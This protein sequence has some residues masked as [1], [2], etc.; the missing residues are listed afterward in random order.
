MKFKVALFVLFLISNVESFAQCA[1][2]RATLENNLSNGNPGIAIG[3]NFGILYL[4]FAPYF[5]VG[6]I[7]YFW[8]KTSKSN[9]FKE[10]IKRH[11]AR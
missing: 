4:L 10:S 1:M 11:F 7:A 6:V 8:Y 9:A 3:I 5:A 2:C